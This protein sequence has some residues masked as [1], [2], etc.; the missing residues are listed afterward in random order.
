MEK[1]LFSLIVPV[2]KNEL[3]LPVTVPRCVEF[4]RTLEGWDVELIFVND[5]SPDNSYAL[6]KEFQKQHPELIRLVNMSK[7]VGQLYAL[8]AGMSIARGAVVGHLS[9]DLQDPIEL[10]PVMLETMEES[11]VKVVIGER[12]ERQ[13]RG[14]G[15]LFAKATHGIIH[16]FIDRR[17]PVGGFDFFIL[18]REVVDRLLAIDEKNGSFQLLVLWMGYEVRSVPYVRKKREIGKSGWTFQKKFKMLVDIITTNSYIPLRF[19]SSVGLVSAFAGFLYGL[20]N[21]VLWIVSP[22]SG[23]ARGWTSL[24]VLIT[25][26]SGMILFSLGVI[27]EYIWRIF[28]YVK[29]RPNYIIDEVIDET[30]PRGEAG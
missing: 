18:G 4:A 27:G 22:E 2:Y 1:K 9:A 11:K 3:N 5:G 14:L 8:M 10:F 17:Y 7:N 13:E 23:E 15:V 30:V 6:L 12:A 28:D 24:V 21:V 29:G 16:R 19:I 20:F 26:F 25:F